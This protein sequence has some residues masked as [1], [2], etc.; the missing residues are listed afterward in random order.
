MAL[1]VQDSTGAVVTR[2]A[3][4]AADYAANRRLVLPLIVGRVLAQAG[5]GAGLAT[6]SLADTTGG[7][8]CTPTE[9]TMASHTHQFLGGQDGINRPPLSDGPVPGNN[10]FTFSGTDSMQYIA[11]QPDGGGQPF[12]IMQP[13]TYVN[14]MIKL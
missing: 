10:N 1:A 14:Y 11:M 9:A 3:N 13:T 5:A 8:T 12:N 6:H 4:A 7:E 2:G